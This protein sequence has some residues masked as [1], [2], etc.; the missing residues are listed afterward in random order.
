MA[1]TSTSIPAQLGPPV[2]DVNSC[3]GPKARGAGL[4][5]GAIAGG[6]CGTGVVTFVLSGIGAGGA[7][8]SLAGWLNMQGLALAGFAVGVAMTLGVT[9]LSVRRFRPQLSGPQFRRLYL[10]GLAR[11]G[12]W[13]VGS[14]LV[15]FVIIS[16][17]LSNHGITVR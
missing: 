16:P 5:A 8:A 4:L 12:G 10:R 6:C 1:E 14:Y 15:W 2:A 7:A 17:I 11:T 3:V 9:Y 13:A